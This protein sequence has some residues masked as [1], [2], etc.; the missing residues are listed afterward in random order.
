MSK[1][2]AR[3]ALLCAL[4]GLGASVA[5]TYVHYRLIVDPSYSSFCDVSASVSC[6]QVYLSPYSTF[7]GIPVAVL[8]ALWF[9]GAALLVGIGLIAGD[10]VREN[11]TGY[12]FAAS[13]LAMAV[14]LYFEY[15]SFSILKLVCVL[16]LVMAGSVVA[17]FFFTGAKTPFP[18]TQLP[19][20]AVQDLR[21]LIATPAA[22]L[23][24]VL[25]LAGAVA[26][27]MLFPR[28]GPEETTDTA[29]TR[30]SAPPP[31][32]A[33]QSEFEGFMATSPRVDLGVASEG[34]TV[35]VVKFNDFQCPPC[36]QSHMAYKP[37]L[38][39]YQ[40]ENPGKVRYVLKDFPL[41]AEC[42]DSVTNTIHPSACE[43]AVAVRLAREHNREEAMIEWVFANQPS[44]TPDLVKQAAREVGQVTDFDAKYA[45]TL[46]LVKRDIALGKQ[47]GV[48]ATP[49]FFIDGL[50][51]DGALPPQYFQQAIEYELKHANAR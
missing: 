36:R 4:V 29:A 26:A 11:V 18:M 34:A 19:R 3:V 5:A 37:I 1:T 13:T 39:K 48:R 12:L 50:K 43:A 32:Q 47:F 14:V 20:R 9:A 38:A 17:L 15:V 33:Q 30:A 22:I 16:C 49:T 8:G 51:L 42:N 35:L 7:R 28:K 27:L 31:S 10:E 6:T 45:S 44:L 46:E 2:A 40:A 41:D 21:R 25:F 23:V 24:T